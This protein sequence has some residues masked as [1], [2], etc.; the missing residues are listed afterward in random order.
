M[1][2]E[3]RNRRRPAGAAG[4]DCVRKPLSECNVNVTL[5]KE[6][7][8]HVKAKQS[9]MVDRTRDKEAEVGTGSHSIGVLKIPTRL[10]GAQQQRRLVSG[11]VQQVAPLPSKRAEFSDMQADCGWGRRGWDTSSFESPY[12]RI[13]SGA[14]NPSDEASPEN[15]SGSPETPVMP[16]SL[17][18]GVLPAVAHRP[19][20]GPLRG[21]VGVGV[22]KDR[23]A[24]PAQDQSFR[25]ELTSKVRLRREAMERESSSSLKGMVELMLG[26]LLSTFK[27]V[28]EA[29]FEGDDSKDNTEE[30]SDWVQHTLPPH[31]PAHHLHA[32][33]SASST[34]DV[35]PRKKKETNTRDSWEDDA[36]RA[37]DG[38]SAHRGEAGV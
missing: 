19:S 1:Q 32:T 11:F 30:F 10:A 7:V 34:S 28:T 18:L 14:T 24:V 25:E 16:L 26:R 35:K 13:K 5:Q 33:A 27:N 31:V 20:G 23:V 29:M 4:D 36:W 21:P 22:L 2:G 9:P 6:R 8:L 17:S 38:V 15:A 12:K 3:L 37:V